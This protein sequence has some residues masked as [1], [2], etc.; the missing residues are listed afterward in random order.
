MTED[1]IEIAKQ[2][3][4]LKETHKTNGKVAEIMEISESQVSRYIA[5]L[6]L[7][8]DIQ[9][10]VSQG[11]LPVAQPLRALK[12]KAKE[13]SVKVSALNTLHRD[14]ITILAR[15][16]FATQQQIADYTE[17]SLSTVRHAIHDLV[18]ARFVESHTDL[19][20]YVYRL[21]AHGSN[22]A[23]VNKPRHW[24]SGNAIH[25]RVLRNAIELNMR[26][27][28]STAIFVNRK[29][30]WRKGLFPSVGEHLLTFT[31]NG[32]HEKALVIIDDYMMAP[33]RIAHSLYRPH[34]R[35]KSYASGQLVLTWKDVVS[36]AFIYCTDKQ[37][38]L[39]HE[40]FIALNTEEIQ[41]QTVVRH[42]DSVWEAI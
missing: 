30:C 36:I 26:K 27:K 29:E 34:D 18:N 4:H 37:H 14:I 32:K 15:T 35:D 38:T 40:K 9:Q 2:F 6:S 12:R 16:S 8:D 1:P 24:M 41:T 17:K 7:P 3:A 19:R 10:Q 22:I 39:L 5:L 13:R 23:G 20:P 31:H 33:S 42:V 11:E 25:Q 28:N 21:S